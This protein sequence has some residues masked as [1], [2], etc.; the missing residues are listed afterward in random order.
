MSVEDIRRLVEKERESEEQVKKAEEEASRIVEQAKVEAKAILSDVENERHLKALLEQE[1]KKI[2][3]KK[4]TWETE[5]NEALEDL[6]RTANEN[7]EKTVACIVKYV[8]GEWK[9][10][11]RPEISHR[12]SK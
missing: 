5:C 12:L 1:M 9:L 3:A 2:E 7:T 10:N 8:F 6:K 4:R 11:G